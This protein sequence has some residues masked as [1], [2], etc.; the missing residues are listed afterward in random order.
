LK[1]QSRKKN[2]V[3][4]NSYHVLKDSF[5]FRDPGDKSQ[6]LPEQED[7]LCILQKKM[8]EHEVHRCIHERLIK[9]V[10]SILEVD[11]IPAISLLFHLLHDPK[12]YEE[13]LHDHHHL[14]GVA[15]LES[16]QA[17]GKKR[18]REGKEENEGKRGSDKKF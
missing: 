14:C 16:I 3:Y 13:A 11:T 6:V 4:H 18:P 5:D 17:S 12:E 8:L 1:L 15:M 9:V 10:E 7:L 2:H